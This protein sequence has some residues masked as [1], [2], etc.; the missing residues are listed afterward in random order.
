[1]SNSIVSTSGRLAGCNALITG[2]GRGIGEA[3]ARKF[4]K[5]GAT[6]WLADIDVTAGEAVAASLRDQGHSAHFHRLDVTDEV[7]W[8]ALVETIVRTDGGLD[9]LVNNA[10]I[11]PVSSLENTSLDAFRRVMQVNTESVFLGLRCALPALRL[12][13]GRRT[14]GS[15]IVN[16]SSLLALRAL[17]DNIAYGASKAAVL[18]LGK[19]AAIEFARAGEAIRVNNVLPAVTDTPMVTREIEEWARQGTM[20]SH[21]I[22]ATRRALEQRIPMGR[23]GQPEDIAEAVLFLASN[24]SAFMTGIDLP[25]DG[26]RSAV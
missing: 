10:G 20:G 13:S 4:V 19:C 18:Q 25:V 1:M 24:E 12:R 23:I 11:A 17:P 21:D 5:E 16:L 6:V 26:G 3:I 8:S 9:I 15:A 7:G 14:G 22:A 2:A